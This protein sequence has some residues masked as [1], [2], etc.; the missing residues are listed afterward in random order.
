MQRKTIYLARLLGLFMIILCGWMLLDRK[1]G[2]GLV[3]LLL[4]RPEIKFTYALIALA[5]GL[6]MVL[7]HNVWRGGALPVVVSVVG[8]LVLV[9]GVA[10][11]VVPAALLGRGL[12]EIRFSQTY[13]SVLAAPFILG[14]YL[15]FAG[16]AA[17]RRAAA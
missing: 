13:A 10:L 5:M 14:L 15:T 4:D 6:A 17:A 2:A 9:K 16:F 11:L 1:D 7:G 12:D 3:Q 8:W